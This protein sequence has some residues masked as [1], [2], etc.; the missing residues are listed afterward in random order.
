MCWIVPEV[1]SGML[2]S[3][4]EHMKRSQKEILDDITTVRHNIQT[5]WGR[6]GRDY[7]YFIPFTGCDC[8]PSSVDNRT[9]QLLDVLEDITDHYQTTLDSLRVLYLCMC[10]RERDCLTASG[11][12]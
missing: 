2:G 4:E 1:A 11:H 10:E 9:T 8:C 5:V 6:I 7:S 3:Q 12:Q